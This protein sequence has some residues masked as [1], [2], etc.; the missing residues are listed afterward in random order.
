MRIFFEK[1]FAENC[2]KMKEFGPEGGVPGI[3]CWIRQWMSFGP[4]GEA[5]TWR[6]FLDPPIVVTLT[7][8]GPVSSLKKFKFHHFRLKY[9]GIE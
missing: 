2:V 8:L 9:S 6:S 5:R 3:R 7:L 1:L 4:P